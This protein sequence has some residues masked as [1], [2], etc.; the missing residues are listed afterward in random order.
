MQG[1]R[2]TFQYVWDNAP[3]GRAPD[4]PLRLTVMPVFW[5]SAQGCLPGPGGQGGRG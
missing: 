5:K 4:V 3:E 1:L 2:E